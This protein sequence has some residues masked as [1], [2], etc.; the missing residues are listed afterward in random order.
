MPVPKSELLSALGSSSTNEVV[1]RLRRVAHIPDALLTDLSVAALSE[2]WGN[3]NYALKKYLA[4]HMACRCG[5]SYCQ[6]C[7]TNRDPALYCCGETD[8]CPLGLPF[9]DRE[10]GA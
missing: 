10:V 6:T 7:H 5:S 3:G 2:T 9:P 4:V 8:A 1:A